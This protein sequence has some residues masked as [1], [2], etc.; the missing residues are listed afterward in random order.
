MC[1][2]GEGRCALTHAI[3]LPAGTTNKEVKLR[4]DWH[5]LLSHDDHLL[6]RHYSSEVYPHADEYVCTVGVVL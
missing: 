3:T 6:M 4:G 2:E 5:S 1:H